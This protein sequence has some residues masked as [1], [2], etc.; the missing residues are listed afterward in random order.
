[1]PSKSLKEKL[2]ETLEKSVL[3][4][5]VIRYE[6]MKLS[7]IIFQE[8]EFFAN[9]TGRGFHLQLAYDILMTIPPTSVESERTFS[10]AGILC[11]KIRSS[12]GDNT[13]DQLVFLRYFFKSQV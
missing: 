2:N 5:P 7:Q 4:K 6:K 10:I 11:N 13:L 8:M 3:P 12:L 1:M 9:G